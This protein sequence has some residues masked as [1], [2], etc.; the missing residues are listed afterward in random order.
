MASNFQFQKYKVSLILAEF[1]HI[2]ETRNQKKRL[3]IYFQDPSRTTELIEIKI[4]SHRVFVSQ[5]LTK[6]VLNLGEVECR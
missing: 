2:L 1:R 3:P 4:S 6:S 5:D